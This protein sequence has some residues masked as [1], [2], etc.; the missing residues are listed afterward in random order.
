ML[1]ILIPGICS[2]QVIDHDI[3]KDEICEKFIQSQSVQKRYKITIQQQY[4]I[5]PLEMMSLTE[6][7]YLLDVDTDNKR[8]HVFGGAKNEFLEITL[9]DP[10]YQKKEGYLHVAEFYFDNNEFYIWG[11]DGSNLYSRRMKKDGSLYERDDSF[12]R[13]LWKMAELFKTAGF[14]GRGVKDTTGITL[15]QFFDRHMK[16]QDG[17]GPFFGAAAGNLLADMDKS[18]IL[19]AEQG[20]F[21][22]RKCYI[23]KVRLPQDG[24]NDFLKEGMDIIAENPPEFIQTLVISQDDLLLRHVEYDYALKAKT[25]DWE[26]KLKDVKVKAKAKA[27]FEYPSDPLTQLKGVTYKDKIIGYMEEREGVPYNIDP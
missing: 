14:Y 11:Q 1:F 24:L 21:D 10:Y 12:R 26:G 27:D 4:E 23:L 6:I 20:E 9:K 5:D 3:D 22:G 8:M 17:M 13:Y 7:K 16:Y 19:E 25:Y 18:S 15:E 2:S